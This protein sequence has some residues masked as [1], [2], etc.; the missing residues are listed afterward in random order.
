MKKIFK[1]I[2]THVPIRL[3]AEERA[4]LA[5]SAETLLGVIRGLGI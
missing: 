4:S 5:R 3:S 2:E 1:F